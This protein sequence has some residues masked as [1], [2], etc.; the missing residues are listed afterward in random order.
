[1]S[2]DVEITIL[3][4]KYVL[5]SEEDEAHLREVA[6]YVD[7]QL[8]EVGRAMTAAP[9]TVAVMGALNIASEFFEYRRKVE[10]AI[11]NLESQSDELIRLVEEQM[12]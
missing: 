5:R 8:T 9:T 7:E 11:A 6:R 12:G 3:N 1:M 2:R 10:G 4:R